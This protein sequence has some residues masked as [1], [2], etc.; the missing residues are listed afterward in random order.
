MRCLKSWQLCNVSSVW[1]ALFLL[2]PP[3]E[4]SL[5][6]SHLP[7][8]QWGHSCLCS[9]YGSLGW[10]AYICVIFYFISYCTTGISVLFDGH[11]KKQG[12][13]IV[14]ENQSPGIYYTLHLFPNSLQTVSSLFWEKHFN[15]LNATFHKVDILYSYCFSW[16]VETENSRAGVWLGC[17][18]LWGRG[19]YT[20]LFLHFL[21]VY[22]AAQI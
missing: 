4:L 12:R 3:E 22:R 9:L 14:P 10:A 19:W 5:F 7:L 17:C 16:N 11:L 20:E 6:P 18:W 21:K 8:W 13:R 2:V 1:W 15:V